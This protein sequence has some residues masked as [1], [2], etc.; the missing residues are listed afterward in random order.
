MT[1]RRTLLR[2]ERGL[3]TSFVVKAVLFFAGLGFVANDAGQIIVAQIKGA[4]AASA[5]AQAAADDYKGSKNMNEAWQKA[6]EAAAFADPMSDIM[7]V[8]VDRATGAATVTVERRAHT[9]IVSN[10]SALKHFGIRQVTVSE[11]HNS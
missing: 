7:S 11:T 4:D 1:P 9:L 8:T 10:V 6:R 5:A 3:V 2:D